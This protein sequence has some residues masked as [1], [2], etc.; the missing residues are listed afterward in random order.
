M[1]YYTTIGPLGTDVSSD[2]LTFGTWEKIVDT[3]VSPSA[4]TTITVTGLDLDA[5]KAYILLFRVTNPTGSTSN[6]SLYY[7]NDTTATNYYRQ[8]LYGTSTTVGASRINDGVISDVLAGQEANLLIWIYRDPAGYVRA[9]PFENSRDPASLL[10][11]M[12]FHIWVTKA[13][14]TRIDLTA[15]VTGSIGVGSNLIIFKVSK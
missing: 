11:R 7:N 13:N 15:S 1:S 14:V 4:V 9:M 10:L 3:T 8:S 2:E 6:I 5:A 12:L